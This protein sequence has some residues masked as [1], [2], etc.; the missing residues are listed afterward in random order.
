MT[1]A[2]LHRS[3]VGISAALCPI[4]G[5]LHASGLNRPTGFADLVPADFAGHAAPKHHALRALLDAVDRRMLRLVITYGSVIGRFGLPGEAHYALANGRM[6]ELARVLS[7][8]L[9]ECRV[10]DV[11]WTVWSGA[12]MGERLDVLDTLGRAGVVPLPVE[13]G[14]E[15]LA[16]V[17]EAP[18]ETH[19]V[20]VS[21]RLPQLDVANGKP[22][23]EH[24]FLRRTRSW[25]PGV[26]L[27]ADVEISVTDDPY[28]TDHRIDGALVLPAVCLLEAMAQAATVVTG[29]PVTAVTDAR[30]ARPV[31]VPDDGRR[32]IRVSA[33]AREDGDVDVVVRS[34][35]TG[36][37][38]DH[39]AGIA[40]RAE[41]APPE[42]PDGE[43][44]PPAHVGGALYGPLF[45]HG[46]RFHR[47]GAYVHLEATAC[48]AVLRGDRP[49]GFG[50]GLPSALQ[51]G[52]PARNDAS[53][54]VLQG[55]VPHRRLL[56]T[57]C[58]RFTVHRRRTSGDLTLRA[59]EREHSG[60]EY[61]YDVVLRD[62]NE[63]PVVSWSGLRLRDVGPLPAP[64]GRPAV[65]IGPYLTG[66]DHRKR[67]V[68]GLRMGSG[69]RRTVGPAVGLLHRRADA[70][71][72]RVGGTGPG[73]AAHRPRLS[74]R[75]CAAHCP[76]RL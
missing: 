23:G 52:D 72:Q 74:R 33:L 66:R 70:S 21:G 15:L 48:T 6:R 65:V 73:T 13:R 39:A 58:E 57:G 54:H 76:P 10:Y 42:V 2:A 69:R 38:I 16:Q 46:P 44:R 34:D 22:Q 31:V 5:I 75:K 63:R 8:E 24:R 4:A 7:H 30:F 19:A 35:E 45:F 50:P 18:P 36:F 67:R 14:V 40:T 25:T 12:G 47:L 32:T 9:P 61:T 27:V 26:E 37:A 49:W 68:G 3:V 17:A 51:F 60:A 62:I 28:L 71:L 11:D 59:I 64:G 53:I 20:L 56:P 43:E 55:C 29:G 41:A 1:D